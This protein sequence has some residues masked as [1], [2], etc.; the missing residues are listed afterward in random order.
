MFIYEKLLNASGE[1]SILQLKKR[2]NSATH[3]SQEEAEAT[4]SLSLAE[5]KWDDFLERLDKVRKLKT[6]I[7]NISRNLSV[8]ALLFCLGT[9]RYVN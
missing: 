4:E 1:K 9:P 7:Y 5:K 2:L 6:K 8:Y 3:A